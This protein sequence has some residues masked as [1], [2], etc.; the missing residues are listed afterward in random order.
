[1]ES[2]TKNTKRKYSIKNKA[3]F[4]SLNKSSTIRHGHSSDKPEKEKLHKKTQ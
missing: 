4:W 2:K 1:M 3:F